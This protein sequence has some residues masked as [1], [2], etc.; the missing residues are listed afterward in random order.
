M[1][2]DILSKFY[3]KSHN[4]KLNALKNAGVISNEDFEGLKKETL[5]LPSDVADQMIENYIMNYEFPFGVALNFVIDGKELLI[6]MVTEEPS[7]VAAA[8]NA[9][10]MVGLSGGF[11]TKMD[12]RLMIAQ[13]VLKDVVS[14][15]VAQTEIL[16]KEAEIIELANAA[17]P[18]ILNYGGGARRVDVRIISADDE[19]ETPEFL[20]VHLV[21]DTGEAMGANIVNTMAEAVA[22][23]VVE[24]ADGSSLMNILSNYATESLAMARCVID[25][26]YLATQSMTGEMVRDRIVEATQ[27]ALADPYRA[28]THNKGIMNGIDA[29]LLATG[30]DWRAVEAGVHA[31]AAKSGQY[32]SL[33]RWTKDADGNLVG[34]LEVPISVGSVGGTLSIHPGA[35]FAYRLLNQPNANELSRILVSVGLAQNLSAVRALVTEG[36]QKGHMGLQARALA[37][38][39]GATDDEIEFVAKRLQ[40]A[41]HMNSETAK[42]ILA[43]LSK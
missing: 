17:H 22:P 21:V 28:V 30:N 16:A 20:A 43:D 38:R 40:T 34:E 2:K 19:F 11:E 10:K 41:K 4:E 5:K 42:N 8:S 24:L 29:V 35:Q 31:Y 32:R 18:S 3:K 27:F 1:K 36:I 25:P 15:E 7:V 39:V 14:V 23:Y 9:G 12:T 13:I 37:I 26:K 33:S 6:P